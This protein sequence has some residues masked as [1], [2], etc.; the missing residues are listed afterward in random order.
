MQILMLSSSSYGEYAYLEYAT[1]WISELLGTSK[2][3]LFIPYAGVTIRWADYTQ[4]VQL[5]LPDLNITGIHE[6]EDPVDA[7][8]NAKTIMV[9]GGN[10]FNL[11]ANLYK[12]E[13]LDPLRHCVERG[14]KYIG[15]S[16]GSNICGKTIS[17]TNDMPIIEPPSFNAL[18]FVNAQLNPHYTDFH[19]EGFHGETRDQRIQ[20]FCVLHP[21][22]PVLGIREGTALLRTN[23]SLRLLGNLNGELFLNDKKTPFSDSTDLSEYL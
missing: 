15:W 9:G 23:D 8:Q 19:P 18:G 22:T 20:E 21:S 4:K 10:T 5:A 12:Y 16:A 3:V 13:L 17:T 14:T 1:T 2:N 11:L 6:Y 7:I